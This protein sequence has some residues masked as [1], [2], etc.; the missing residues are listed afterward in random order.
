[1][2]SAG[3]GEILVVAHQEKITVKKIRDLPVSAASGLVIIGE[4]F[5][6]IADDA[7]HLG[8]YKLDDPTFEKTIRLRDGEL[9]A[10]KKE[11]KKVKPDFEAL[12]LLPP[13]LSP[14]QNY[15]YG[16]LLAL[17][18]G[19]KD[20]RQQAVLIPFNVQGNAT[21]NVMPLDLTTLYQ[22]L[23]LADCNIEGA[24]VCG[25]KIVLM[26][27]GNNQHK[28]SAL[29]HCSLPALLQGEA[30][31]S[32][33]KVHMPQIGDVPFGFTD[34][35]LLPNGNIL[36]SAVAEDTDNSVADGAC[37]GAAIGEITMQGNIVRYTI[38]PETHKIE[39][40]ALSDDGKQ[41]YAVTDADDP[42]VK[43]ELLEIEGWWR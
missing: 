8:V 18:S 31:A 4:T 27:R 15:P 43:A 29:I 6:V 42:E 26:H 11:R 25:E 19:S 34:G 22:S 38:L 17:G 13:Q 23:G 33:I 24:V 30:V 2:G 3:E 21:H 5:Y 14:V 36:F 10:D 20:N 28:K 16:A 40:I 9:P 35:L 32:V 41:L 12:V 1:M 37:L 39:G 7:L